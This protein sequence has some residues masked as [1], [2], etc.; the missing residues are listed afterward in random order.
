MNFQWGA[1]RVKVG[2][3]CLTSHSHAPGTCS[4]R[5][6]ALFCE[7][8][9]QKAREFSPSSGGNSPYKCRISHSKFL[10][11]YKAVQEEGKH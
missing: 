4:L 9:V 1:C 5:P 10:I 11:Q 2:V 7:F 6:K 3:W 8:L